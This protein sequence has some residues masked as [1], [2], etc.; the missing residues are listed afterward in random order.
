MN[1]MRGRGA[2][3]LRAGHRGPVER[4]TCSIKV[5]VFTQQF[6]PFVDQLRAMRTSLLVSAHAIGRHADRPCRRRAALQS[7]GVPIAVEKRRATADESSDSRKLLANLR[8]CFLECGE[9]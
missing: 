9:N 3:K 6:R 1:V 5:I 7:C 2:E 4:Y 8:G